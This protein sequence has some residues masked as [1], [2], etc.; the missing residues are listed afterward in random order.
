MAYP[1]LLSALAAE[2][3]AD[4]RRAAARRRPVLDGEPIADLHREA[5][6]HCPVLAAL[7]ARRVRRAAAAEARL[8]VQTTAAVERG[9]E[10]LYDEGSRAIDKKTIAQ[11]EMH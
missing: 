3:I 2:R 11:P 1:P 6:W 8:S 9:V 7:R 10:H 4:L 5:A